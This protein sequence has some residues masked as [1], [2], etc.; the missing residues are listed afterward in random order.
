MMP[1]TDSDFKPVTL[2][3]LGLFNDYRVRYY[4]ATPKV[5]PA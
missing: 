1:V 5:A 3:V 2:Q 4:E